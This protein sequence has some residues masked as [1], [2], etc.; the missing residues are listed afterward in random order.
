MRRWRIRR[1]E[2]GS[3][4]RL[5]LGSGAGCGM[6]LRA[7]ARGRQGRS[8]IWRSGRRGDRGKQRPRAGHRARVGAR[9]GDRRAHRAGCRQGR[10]G[11][12]GRSSRTLPTQSST[13]DARPGQPRFGA[14]VR[15]PRCRRPRPRRHAGQQRRRDDAAA[16]RRPRRLRAAV[17]HQPPRP[18]RAH[19]AAAR[20]A[21][22]PATARGWSPCPASSIGRAA[23]DF[24]DLQSERQL[25][26]ARVPTPSRSSPTS[27]FGLELDRRL[28][29]AGC[30]R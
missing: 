21:A 6:I 25:L 19:R 4:T 23:F 14:R 24:D 11:A 2:R 30:R 15:R 29:A 10:R 9:R 28:R 5:D 16:A 26:A 18:L 17:R 22:R 3:W 1:R 20:R 7:W 27:V 12:R 13:P 8:A